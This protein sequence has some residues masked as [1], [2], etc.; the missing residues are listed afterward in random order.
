MSGLIEELEQT[1]EAL[2]VILDDE[3]TFRYVLNEVFQAIDKDRDGNLRREELKKFV[4]KVCTDMGMKT[5]PD[6]KAIEEVFRDLDEDNSEDI[7]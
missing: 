5:Q 6:D 4:M 3:S 2:K 7:N 1:H